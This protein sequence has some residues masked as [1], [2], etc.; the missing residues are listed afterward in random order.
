VA[1]YIRRIIITTYG[2]VA[3]KYTT[4]PDVLIPGRENNSEIENSI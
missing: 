1:P 2:K 3:V 4:F